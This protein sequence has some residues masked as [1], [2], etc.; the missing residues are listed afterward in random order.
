MRTT[1]QYR[2]FI[3]GPIETN[4]F[5]VFS[6]ESEAALVDPVLLSPEMLSFIE[7]RGL[8][9]KAVLITHSHADHLH[10]AATAAERFRAP[11]YMHSAAEKMRSFYRE[12]CV[13]LG[14]EPSE[15]PEQYIP[16]ETAAPLRLGNHEISFITTPGHSPCGISLLSDTFVITGDLLFEDDIGR[17]DLP[18]SSLPLLYNSLKKIK[19]LSPTLEVLPGH[20]PLTTLRRELDHNPYLRKLP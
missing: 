3:L 4:A 18:F 8:A 5:V 2:C 10:G 13:M 19:A 11:V 20:G 1:M 15:M 9:V 6:P 17:Y 7:E 14:F 16:A 12:S